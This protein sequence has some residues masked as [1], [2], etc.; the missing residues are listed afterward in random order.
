MRAAVPRS[1]NLARLLLPA[2]TAFSPLERED[3]ACDIPQVLQ[4]RPTTR[5]PRL[6]IQTRAPLISR[7]PA[8]AVWG[9]GTL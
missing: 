1:T 5:S 8:A 7:Y 4:V 2:R 6:P 3:R 9:V